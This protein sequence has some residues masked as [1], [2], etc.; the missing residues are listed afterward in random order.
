V[1]KID[2]IH[3][4]ARL[5]ELATDYSELSDEI[6]PLIAKT[7]CPDIQENANL[8]P[9]IEEMWTLKTSGKIAA[10]KQYRARTK[11]LLLQSKNAIEAAGMK[12]GILDSDGRPL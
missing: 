1:D 6:L 8:E 11:A 5:A 10:I 2:R 9:S 12:L 4:I 3:V 7:A